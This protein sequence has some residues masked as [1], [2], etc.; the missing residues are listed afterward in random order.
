[1]KRDYYSDSIAGFL[2]TSTNEILG[3]LARNSGFT[4]EQTQRDAWLEEVAILKIAL[5]NIDGMIYFEYS[6][7]RMG[8]RIDTILLIGSALFVLEFKIGDREFTSYAMN[9]AYDYAL[10]L[11]NLLNPFTGFSMEH[12]MFA[13]PFISR[14]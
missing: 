8:K 4:I 2:N 7:P 14:T 1:M 12:M 10:D 9:Q 6:I 11:K 5:L 13:H 3:T